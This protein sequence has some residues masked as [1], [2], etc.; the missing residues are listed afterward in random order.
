MRLTEIICEERGIQLLI[1]FLGDASK[2]A[3]ANVAGAL[4]SFN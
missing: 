1:K 3:Q 2:E 4:S